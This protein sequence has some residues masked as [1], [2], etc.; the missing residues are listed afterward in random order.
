MPRVVALLAGELGLS[1]E[2]ITKKGQGSEFIF[3][4][5]K[6][7]EQDHLTVEKLI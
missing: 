5:T 2:D 3:R 1:P 6:D 7:V 4:P